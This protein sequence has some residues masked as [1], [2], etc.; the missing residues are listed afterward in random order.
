VGEGASRFS[1]ESPEWINRLLARKNLPSVLGTEGFIKRIKGKFVDKKR[2]REIHE[3]KFL[4]PDADR[5]NVSGD[6]HK[7]LKYLTHIR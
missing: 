2:Q 6:V 1:K 3:S 5:I 4:V 7:K